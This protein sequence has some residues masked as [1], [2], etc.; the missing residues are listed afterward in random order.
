M[1]FS[2][3][4]QCFIYGRSGKSAGTKAHAR[5][6]SLSSQFFEEHINADYNIGKYKSFTAGVMFVIL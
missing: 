2:I 4:Q 1:I 5:C 3:F 6:R